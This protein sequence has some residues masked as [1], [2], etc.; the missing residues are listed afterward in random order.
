MC[1]LKVLLV[2][3][4]L[5][6]WYVFCKLWRYPGGPVARVLRVNVTILKFIWCLLGS[7]CRLKQCQLGT[8]RLVVCS[9]KVN[10]QWR[11]MSIHLVMLLYCFHLWTPL[12]INHITITW[13]YPSFHSHNQLIAVII[14]II[15]I[16][17]MTSDNRMTLMGKGV[18]IYWDAN[19]AAASISARQVIWT[20]FNIPTEILLNSYM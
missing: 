12:V 15:I 1:R 20:I 16:F 6:G 10:K 18:F 8:F 5:T 14:I 4:Y 3:G 19:S 11:A 7:Q 9:N 2:G 17:N 13:M